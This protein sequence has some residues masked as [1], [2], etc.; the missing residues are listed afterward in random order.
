MF[1]SMLVLLT[2]ADTWIMAL[3]FV[4]SDMSSGPGGGFTV[5]RVF[6]LLR[7]TRMAR[8]MRLLR[9]IPEL[10]ILVRGM[11]AA[12]RSVALTLVLLTAII[13]TYA[14]ILRQVT[15]GTEIGEQYFKSI[16]ASMS[17]LLLHATL[18]DMSEILHD[19]GTAHILLGTLLLT[20][21]LLASLTVLNMLIGVL[22]E[23]VS[24]VASVEREELTLNTVKTSMERIMELSGVDTDANN[25]ISR[26]EFEQLLEVPTAAR[27]INE[28]GVDVVGLIDYADLIFDGGQKELSFSEF[29]EVLLSLRGKNAATVK[30]IVDLRKFIYA[31]VSASTNPQQ[32]H[33]PGVFE[34]LTTT[35]EFPRIAPSVKSQQAAS[36]GSLVSDESV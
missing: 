24:V 30:D 13:Y 27:L 12:S 4:F 1:D 25:A 8:M 22:V 7:L 29:F 36:V 33:Q 20:F 34:R 26:A 19:T 21:I 10:M 2:V 28:I 17:S 16:P 15:D 3:V 32:Q 31:T 11:A 23:V 14:I 35:A 5:L 18:P 9:A 6:R